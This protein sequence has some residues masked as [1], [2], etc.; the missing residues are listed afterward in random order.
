MSLVAVCQGPG[1]SVSTT[2]GLLVA[3]SMPA[4]QPVI[5]AE[6]DPSGGD[7]TGWARLYATPSWRSAVAAG[8]RSWSGLQ[9]HLQQLPSGLSVMVSPSRAAEARIVVREAESRFAPMLA[10]MSD[11]AVVADC[12]RVVDA[13]PAWTRSAQ[14]VVLLVRQ[15]GTSAAATVAR[16]D[17]AV[18]TAGLLQQIDGRVGLVVVGARPYRPEQIAEM[19]DCDLVGV[20]PEDPA[21]A[22]L[23]AGAWT[24][25]RGVSR[26]PL[27]R[28]ARPIAA[29]IV[30]ALAGGLPVAGGV[31]RQ[32]V[33]T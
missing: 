19:V 4:G 18:E 13:A 25:G 29:R 22:G 33:E 20:L 16:V 12:G 14:F 30:E 32:E 1:T 11:V 21:G 28:A 9:S 26:S 23:V 27:A 15:A 5:F 24:V 3:S 10:A 31:R 8:D 2:S 6:C 17:R 7:L